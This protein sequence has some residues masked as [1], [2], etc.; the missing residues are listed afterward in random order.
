VILGVAVGFT[1]YL[2]DAQVPARLLE[3]TQAHIGS[4]FVFL[5]GLNLFLLVVGA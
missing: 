1:N 2:I 3:W 5:L 4:P